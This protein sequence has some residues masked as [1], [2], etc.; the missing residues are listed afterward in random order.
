MQAPLS[1]WYMICLCFAAWNSQHH[2]LTIL[3]KAID[4]LMN[5]STSKCK[6]TS[7]EFYVAVLPFFLL[8]WWLPFFLLI[9]WLPA[10][11]RAIEERAVKDAKSWWRQIF[12]QTRSGEWIRTKVRTKTLNDD[13]NMFRCLTANKAVKQFLVCRTIESPKLKRSTDKEAIK[14]ARKRQAISEM[15]ETPTDLARVLSAL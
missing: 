3:W 15:M 13:R 4:S 5:T 14:T 10:N 12:Q 7:H 11:E 9:W 8:Q 2:I 6:A 1:V